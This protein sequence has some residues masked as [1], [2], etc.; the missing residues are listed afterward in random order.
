MTTMVLKLKLNADFFREMY[1]RE[2][3]SKAQ[4]RQELKRHIKDE[5]NEFDV[6]EVL[7]GMLNLKGAFFSSEVEFRR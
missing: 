5:V 2:G 7:E 1:E 6:R 3:W 4:L